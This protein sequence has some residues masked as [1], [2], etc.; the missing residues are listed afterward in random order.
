MYGLGWLGV[1]RLISRYQLVESVFSMLEE[2]VES[3]IQFRKALV[4]VIVDG[5]GGSQ[6]RPQDN[7]GFIDVHGGWNAN[8]RGVGKYR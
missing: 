5:I 8:C 2:S 3:T 4:D 7:Q 1:S 6:H